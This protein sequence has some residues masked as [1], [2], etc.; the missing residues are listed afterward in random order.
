MGP[1]AQR[2]GREGDQR[3]E[4]DDQG[5][6]RTTYDGG[7][8]AA[9]QPAPADAPVHAPQQRHPGPV[10]PAAELGEQ[11]RQHGDRADHGHAD[12]DDGAGGER[13]ERRTADD[14]EPGHR[15]D[16]GATGHHDRVARGGGGDLDG[17]EGAVPSGPLLALPL[18][19]EQRVVDTD[20]HSDQHDHAGHGGL[21][22][23]Q[24][25]ERGGDAHRRRHRREGEQHGHAGGDQG[26]E[27]EQHQQQGDREADALGGV[28]VLA[29][30]V[31]DGG[32]HREVARLADPEI[33][34]GSGDRSRPGLDLLR[35][36]DGALQMDVDED[37]GASG[38]PL[39]RRDRGDARGA[40]HRRVDLA[41]NPSYVGRV[42]AATVTGG[43]QQALDLVVGEPPGCREGVGSAGLPEPVVGVGRLLGR[44][45]GGEG[46]GGRDEREPG[47]DRTPGMGGAPPGGAQ[48]QPGQQARAVQMWRH[49]GLLRSALPGPLQR[50]RR[51][52]PGQERE[53]PGRGWC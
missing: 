20:G 33:L 23:D 24:V 6:D 46:D 32:V 21:G 22:M 27:G 19:V 9:A 2:G 47:A 43:D 28:Q 3:G 45:Q 10:D 11:R 38:V 36:V 30:P 52:P 15:G 49:G 41:G 17:V 1:H 12:H 18:E 13:V 16:H 29:D 37:A 26:A 34:M 5:S 8:D 51:R 14:E 40:G 7:Q 53:H 42:E 35:I 25:R 39:R 4:R 50:R 31:V 44:D 48:G